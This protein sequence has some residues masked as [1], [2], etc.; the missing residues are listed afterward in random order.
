MNKTNDRQKTK[1][2]KGQN[3]VNRVINAINPLQNS[4]Y[5]WD[6][7]FFRKSIAVEHK[8]DQEKH[9]IKQIY[10]WNPMI[11]GFIM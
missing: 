10:I 6:I 8:T 7:F 3:N 11:T 1:G 2:Y 5:S 9:K 4:Q